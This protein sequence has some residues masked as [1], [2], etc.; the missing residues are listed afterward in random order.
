MSTCTPQ[1]C[2]FSSLLDQHLLSWLE[3]YQWTKLEIALTWLMLT[4]YYNHLV[5]PSWHH[6]FSGSYNNPGIS[7]LWNF[8]WEAT[9]DQEFIHLLLTFLQ[10]P[11]RCGHLS[12]GKFSTIGKF[13]HLCAKI[14][15]NSCLGFTDPHSL[16]YLLFFFLS[17]IHVTC[18]CKLSLLPSSG[19]ANAS[20]ESSYLQLPK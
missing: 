18:L 10:D 14:V 5:G 3:E 8:D 15:L 19:A 2:R 12:I 4:L 17:C 6:L 11:K 16:R 13:A 20:E 1:Y 7:W 9:S